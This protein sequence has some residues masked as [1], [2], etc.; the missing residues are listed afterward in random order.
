[1]MNK[2][3]E[4]FLIDTDGMKTFIPESCVSTP[5]YSN[6]N[7]LILVVFFTDDRENFCKLFICS[8]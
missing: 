8:H 2:D 6:G 3:K 1:M 4:L 5:E 7:I